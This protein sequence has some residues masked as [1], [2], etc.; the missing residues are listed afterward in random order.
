[1]PQNLAATINSADPVGTNSGAGEVIDWTADSA[2]DVFGS[3]FGVQSEFRARKV[4]YDQA[5]QDAVAALKNHE[6]ATREALT[7]F[8]AV[9]PAVRATQPPGQQSSGIGGRAGQAPRTTTGPAGQR[10]T[11]PPAG[12]ADTSSGHPAHHDR[13]ARR[14]GG[15]RP[16]R[17]SGHP[18][19]ATPARPHTPR[20]AADLH[21]QA[22]AGLRSRGLADPRTDHP[23]PPLTEALRLLAHAGVEWDLWLSHATVALGATRGPSGLVVIQCEAQFSLLTM[24]AGRVPAAL[25]E[26]VGPL[27]PGRARAVNIPADALDAARRATTDGNLWTLA[28]QLVAGGLD[29]TDAHSLAHVC[30]GIR[31]SVQVGGLIRRDG[32]EHR[33][34]W[35]VGVH[36]TEHGD[37]L[38][39]RRPGQ[40][41]QPAAVTVAPIT[42]DRL[43]AQVQQ[44]VPAS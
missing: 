21:T 1:M 3:T 43:L 28:D 5:N 9:I 20:T 26:L 24:P 6:A 23:S 44:L 25:V 22:F 36:R 35:V 11:T 2:N 41:N 14:L 13:A 32:I 10:P 8:Q 38:Q 39:L 16:T 18:R 4:A 33:T 7:T 15:T 27:N 17:P 42:A 34:D 19:P 40:P 29:R 31:S 30:T 12:G 37:Y